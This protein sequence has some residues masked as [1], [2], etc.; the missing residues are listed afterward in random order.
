MLRTDHTQ[1][2]VRFVDLGGAKLLTVGWLWRGFGWLSERA[3]GDAMSHPPVAL[4]FLSL[5]PPRPLLTRLPPLPV[6]L[7]SLCSTAQPTNTPKPRSC[8]KALPEQPNRALSKLAPSSRHAPFRSPTPTVPLRTSLQR[9]RG[10]KI[11]TLSWSVCV[12]HVVP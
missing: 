11:V 8:P 5:S 3:R 4:R 10:A 2:L 12:E 6:P 9:P 1:D 7:P